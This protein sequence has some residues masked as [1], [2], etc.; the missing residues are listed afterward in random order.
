MPEKDWERQGELPEGTKPGAVAVSR[1]GF[2]LV[3]VTV[4]PEADSLLERMRGRRTRLFRAAEGS[5]T[6][7]WEGPG[8]VQAVDCNGPLCAAIGATLK[9]SGS[10]YHLLVSTDGGREWQARGPVDAPS[11]GQVLAVSDN[12]V[13][14]LGASFLGLTTDGGASWTELELEGE[15]N[16]HRERLRRVEGGVSLLG[17]NGMGVSRDGGASWTFLDLEGLR[18]VDVDEAYVVAVAE[19]VVRVGERQGDDIRWLPPLPE[20]REPLRLVASEGVLRVLTR[21]A[22]PSRGVDPVIHRSEDGG[23]TWSH[24]PLPLGPQVD[25]AGREWGLGVDPRGGVYGRVG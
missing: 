13:W 2:G 23:Q 5:F 4:E 17:P 18:L 14:V 21:S 7:S 25:I 22:D 10:D 15:R 16:P 24:H 12:E 19:G 20:G 8:W 11:V 6:P 9:P 1:D 3:G